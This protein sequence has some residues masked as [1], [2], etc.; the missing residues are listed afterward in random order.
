MKNKTVIITGGAGGL[1]K[2]IAKTLKQHSFNVVIFDIDQTKL[3]AAS[4]QFDAH[5]VNVTSEEEILAAV[6]KVVKDYAS[7]DVL[8]NCAGLIHSEPL[9][10]ITSPSQMRHSVDN[11]QKIININCFSTFLTGSIVAEHMVIK[12][13]KGSI[14][15]FSSISSHGNAG[16]SAYAA[17]KA[18]V[19]ALTKTWAKELGPLGIRVNAISPGFIDT[20]A[21]HAALNEKM[22]TA[23]KS[24][25]P[26]KRL[27][28]TQNI[29][30]AVLYLIDN[31][32]MNGAILDVDGGLII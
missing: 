31:D 12:R 9:I 14:I 28:Q 29:A 1:G 19:N 11:F 24:Q 16:Q 18:A 32:F 30:Q 7:I 10:N 21:T 2:E 20:P 4:L 25:I 23:L 26:L 27:G 22:I 6:E 15:N 13:I 3:K 17:A 5:S 8:I